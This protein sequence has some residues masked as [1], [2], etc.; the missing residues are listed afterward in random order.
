M[1]L[2]KGF[3][4]GSN[5]W[6]KRVGLSGGCGSSSGKLHSEEIKFKTSKTFNKPSNNYTGLAFPKDE[7]DITDFRISKGVAR[8]GLNEKKNKWAFIKPVKDFFMNMFYTIFG[9][10]KDVN[11]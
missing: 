2:P 8:W 1:K 11:R 5:V 6:S 9:D 4:A 3:E 10:D 7:G